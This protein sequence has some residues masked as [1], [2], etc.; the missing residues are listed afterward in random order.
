VPPARAASLRWLFPAA[1]AGR[2]ANT[3]AAAL[4]TE[5]PAAAAGRGANTAAAALPTEAPAAAA[6]RGADTAAAA[7]PDEAPAAPP[8][9]AP[10]G[11]ALAPPPP[12]PPAPVDTA[13]PVEPAAAAAPS[14]DPG[15]ARAAG[16]LSLRWL[17]PS[18]V[19]AAAVGASAAA[20]SAAAAPPPA[21]PPVPAG[22][23]CVDELFAVEVRPPFSAA[24]GHWEYEVV[25]VFRVHA[26]TDGSEG[27]MMHYSLHKRYRQFVALDGALRARV[28][29]QDMPAV[30]LPPSFSSPATWFAGGTWPVGENDEKFLAAR[31]EGLD[32]YLNGLFAFLAV[33]GAGGL[34]AAP[35]VREFLQWEQREELHRLSTRMAEGEP[36]GGG[37]AAVDSVAP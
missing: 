33:G 12:P 13:A 7:P 30:A 25:V 11:A 8:T 19:G 10:A 15:A 21:A 18:A 2:G 6:G 29:T 14:A 17:F 28:G 35:E 37:E 4:P 26:V 32:R 9:E 20:P 16:G 24:A 1:A 31:C 36:G 23:A 3:A 22:G 27:R 34:D 5:A